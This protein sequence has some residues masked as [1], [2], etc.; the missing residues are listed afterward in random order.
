MKDLTHGPV[1]GHVWSMTLFVLASMLLQTVYSVVDLYWIGRLGR[2]AIAAVSVAGNLQII[3]FGLSQILGVGA[4]A[5]VSHAIGRKD[6]P[7]AQRLF[8]QAI[9]L[10]IVLGVAWTIVAFALRGFYADVMSGDAVTA[11]LTREFLLWFIPA[12][13][14][15][16][17]LVALGSCLRGAGNM[18]PGLYAQ[19]ATVVINIVLAPVLI[20]GW[21]TGVALGVAGAGLATFI[22][23]LAGTIGLALHLRHESRQL[24]VHVA[25][26]GPDLRVWKRMTSIGLPSGAEMAVTSAYMFF[27]YALIRPFGAAAQAGFGIGS[28]IMQSGFMPAMAVSFACA[29][30]V[31]QNYAAGRHDRVRETF[32]VGA[33]IATGMMVAFTLLCHLAAEPMTRFFSSDPAVVEVGYDYLLIISWNYLAFGVTVV[34]TGLFQGLGN[35]WPT[36]VG[37]TTRVVVVAFPAWWLSQAPGFRLSQIWWLSVAAVIVQT[38]ICVWFLR[39]TFQR[40]LATASPEDA[41][42]EPA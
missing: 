6:A 24:R 40:R 30:V 27:I 41:A 4:G 19:L 33:M 15:Q 31:G 13:A 38:A 37:Q 18:K 25:S 17:P 22:G 32:W 3:V 9:G 1:R 39:R 20:F 5:V 2:E 34:A 21:G 23:I 35:T 14:L 36:L 8:S 11:L 12:L 16:F 26:L 7:D 42:V 29:A 10:S 28:R